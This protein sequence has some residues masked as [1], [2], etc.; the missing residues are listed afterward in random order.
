MFSVNE[1]ATVD[2]GVDWTIF[3]ALDT[4]FFS[5]SALLSLINF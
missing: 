4:L 3:V 1:Q 5:G 2:Y